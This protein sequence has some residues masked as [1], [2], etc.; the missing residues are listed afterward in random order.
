[1]AP[2]KG[3]S[4]GAS[5]KGGSKPSGPSSASRVGKSSKNNVKRPPPKEVKSKART[6]PEN[7]QK[8]KKRVY[9]EAELNLPKLN[10]ITPVGVVKP[11]GKKKGKTFVDDAVRYIRS[12]AVS[13]K[14]MTNESL[15]ILGGYDDH[16]CYGE[17]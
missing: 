16:S 15:P 3:S 5:D 2:T 11:K 10:S 8:K 13:R 6:A 4:K 1:M 9:T 7:L 17:C 14:Q 12:P